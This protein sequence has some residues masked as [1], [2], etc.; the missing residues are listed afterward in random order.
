MDGWTNRWMDGQTDGWMDEWMDG[1]MDGWME[2]G[3]LE[4][5][6]AFDGSEGIFDLAEGDVGT[7]V[8]QHLHRVVVVF[9]CW[10]INSNYCLYNH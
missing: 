1:Q 10:T 3:Y 8:Q 4:L 6:D 7:L 9:Q 2:G 5:V